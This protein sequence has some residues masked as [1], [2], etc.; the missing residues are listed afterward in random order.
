[1]INEYFQEIEAVKKEYGEGTVVLFQVGAFYEVYGVRHHETKEIYK[2]PIVD[3]SNITGLKLV[4]KKIRYGEDTIVNIGFKN[5]KLEDYVEKIKDE[6]YT[7]AVYDQDEKNN[8]VLTTVISPGTYFGDND[9]LTNNTMAIWIQ[10]FKRI[11]NKEIIVFGIANIDI[12]T[13]K[14]MIFEYQHP[15]TKT[16]DIYDELEKY[17]SIYQPSELLFI[18]NINIESLINYFNITTKSIHKYTIG[19]NEQVNRCEKQVYQD[20]ILKKFFSTDVNDEIFYNYPFATQSLC[21]LLNFIH[22]KNNNLVKKINKPNVDNQSDY[23][24][25]ANHSLKQLNV[26]SEDNNKQKLSS[27]ANFLNNCVTPMGKRKCRHHLVNPIYNDKKLQREYDTTSAIMKKDEINEIRRELSFIRDI[28]KSYRKIILKKVT[29]LEICNLYNN[30][31]KIQLIYTY[32]EKDKDIITFLE[33]ANLKEYC[34]IIIEYIEKV[35]DIDNINDN[36]LDRNIIKNGYNLEHDNKVKNYHNSEDLL[37]AVKDELNIV[38]SKYEK[39][40]ASEIIKI[41][42]TE[43]KGISLVAT[44]R[45]CGYI[46]EEIK[47]KKNIAIP[48]K[49]GKYDL[50]VEKVEFKMVTSNNNAVVNKAFNNICEEPRRT[51]EIMMESNKLLFDDFISQFEELSDKLEIIITFIAN[52]DFQYNKAFVARKYNYHAPVITTENKIILKD[53]RHPLIENMLTNELYVTNDLTFSKEQKGMLLYGVNAIGKSSLMKALGLAVIMAQAG[54]FVACQEMIYRPY[55]RL[56]TRILNNDNIFRGLSTFAVEMIEFKNILN[57]SN[58]RSLI[59]GDE[60][61]SGTENK[62]AIS[63]FTA[64]LDYLYQKECH[65]IFAT[66]LHEILE[67]AEIKD[68]DKLIINHLEVTYDQEKDKMVYDRKLKAGPGLSIYGLEVCKS[69]HMPVSFINKAYEIRN[70]YIE[71][72]DI[73]KYATSKYN[74]KKLMGQCE[75]CKTAFSSEVHHLQ[76]QKDADKNGFIQTFHKNN[77]GN[78][79]AVCGKCH[80]DLHHDSKKGHIKK[81]FL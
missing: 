2:S 27:L 46:K 64:G 70:N 60:L 80:D 49:G 18:H 50:N 9:K 56:F 65:F 34:Q 42:E 33:E 78:L 1:M 57:N 61:C 55:E 16:F 54:F 31:K 72:N 25:L 24:L 37:I 62:S 19:E 63:I 53:L 58:D 10:K 69:L 12:Y 74:A 76:H 73:L 52:V 20:E 79:I 71:N 17:L 40:K 29:P 51:K 13:G 5:I 23:V 14:S 68:K 36:N 43:K 81:L 32:L 48:F 44:K 11:N 26:I 75:M 35:L 38:L 3:I 30:L 22:Q 8:R 6:G 77:L 59:L 21:F 28:E 39:R 41:Y 4:D 7:I 67:F 47:G 66:H 45:R 15:F